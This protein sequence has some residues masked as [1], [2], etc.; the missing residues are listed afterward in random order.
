MGMVLC[1]TIMGGPPRCTVLICI[2][3]A[4][5]TTTIHTTYL[6][7]RYYHVRSVVNRPL[8]H[9]RC[10]L[11]CN[12]SNFDTHHDG[13]FEVT[14]LYFTCSFCQPQSSSPS[15]VATAL[16]VVQY[17]KNGSRS[18][19]E[20][21]NYLEVTKKAVQCFTAKKSFIR[22]VR[23]FVVGHISSHV[24]TFVFIH[25]KKNSWVSCP[26]LF[27]LFLSPFFLN[28]SLI[29]FFFCRTTIPSSNIQ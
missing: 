6:Y 18:L 9:K 1:L 25:T 19:L 7:L 14:T 10:S 13:H 12:R 16:A 28:H 27:L 29:S 24:S 23:M 22:R 17:Q 5:T 15:S 2:H 21:Q 11:H 26:T 4:G 8:S 3:T 20:T